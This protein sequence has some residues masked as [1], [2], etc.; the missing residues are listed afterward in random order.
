MNTND[1]IHEGETVV[2][3][4]PA[5]QWVLVKKVDSSEHVM[6]M[7][8]ADGTCIEKSV[9]VPSQVDVATVPALSS[10]IGQL[11]T[12]MQYVAEAEVALGVVSAGAALLQNF[13]G[14]KE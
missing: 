6:R 2:Q 3:Q 12:G 14:K 5:G 4:D 1:L 8:A 11:Q 10:S 7:R 9:E 13:L